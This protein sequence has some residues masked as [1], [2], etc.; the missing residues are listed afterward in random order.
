MDIEDS[1]KNA[2]RDRTLKIR[3]VERSRSKLP[4]AEQ[5]HGTEA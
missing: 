5:L 4:M 2:D 1:R 3:P